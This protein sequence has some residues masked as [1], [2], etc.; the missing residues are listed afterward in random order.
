MST[1]SPRPWRCLV[2]PHCDGAFNMAL[3]EALLRTF[4]ESEGSPLLRLYG[5]EPSALSLGR[6]QDAPEVLNLEK[7]Q[8]AGVSIVRRITGGG[9]IYHGDELTYSIVCSTADL[10]HETSVKGAYRALTGFLLHA[11]TTLGLSPVF[12]GEQ[13]EAVH[14]RVPFCFAGHESYDI[15]L[16]GKKLGGNAQRRLKQAIFLHGS[17]PLENRSSV[18]ASF[19][20]SPPVGIEERT[21]ALRDQGIVLSAHELQG[22]L[23]SSFARV[24]GLELLKSAPTLEEEG[25]A[26]MLKKT[27]YLSDEWT[28]AGREA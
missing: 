23:C 8:Q 6:Y 4:K 28:F 13:S 12:A 15:L 11:Y 9:V 2:T 26:A 21:T 14:G 20:K 10:P 17:I 24:M 27:K 7:C 18:G 3:D 16:A 25:L 5:W 22:L 19:M 1:T